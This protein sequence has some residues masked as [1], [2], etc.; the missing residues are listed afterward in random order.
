M[1]SK[2]DL[3][4]SR[5]P[6][7]ASL[8]GVESPQLGL[9]PKLKR[10]L[11]PKLGLQGG[12]F[13]WRLRSHANHPADE[14]RAPGNTSRQ[15]HAA[16]MLVRLHSRQSSAGAELP[17]GLGGPRSLIGQATEVPH[18]ALVGRL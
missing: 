13:L 6:S 7:S 17:R 8:P 18:D 12:L 1:F 10:N 4:I 5:G 15:L 9:R 2:E 11:K 14:Y 3:C 16:S